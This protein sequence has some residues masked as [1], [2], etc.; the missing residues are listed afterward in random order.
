MMPAT[1]RKGLGR[2]RRRERLLR[3]A[4]GAARWLAL[5]VTVLALACLTDWVIDRFRDTPWAVRA[6]MT[7]F[8]AALWA[9]AAFMLVLRPVL[10]RL[11]DSRLALW[12]EGKAPQLGHRLIST[13]QFH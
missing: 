2:L 11:S 8:Q 6:A 10:A 1:I 5:A 4:W 3:L 13:V 7:F 12:V 9:A